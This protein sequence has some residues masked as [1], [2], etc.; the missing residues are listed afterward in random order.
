VEP[1]VEAFI[2][3][4]QNREG[5]Q[6][7]ANYGLFLTGLCDVLGIPQPD[8][9]DATT[10]NNDY[11]LERGVR[12]PGRDGSST[13]KRIDLYKRN[14][15][16]LEAKQSRLSGAKKVD[17]G[18][19]TPALPGF[20][21]SQTLGRRGVGRSWDVLMLN[22]R[23]QAEDY[24]RLLPSTHTPP[25]FV[26]VCDVGH[27]IEIY[28]NFR[29]DG[30]AFDQFPD[31]RSFR[32]YLEDLRDE[33]VRNRLRAIWLTPMALDPALHAAAVTRDIATRLAGVTKAL[34]KDGQPPEQAALFLMRVLFTMFA[35]DTGLLP[36]DCFK[37]LLKECEEQPEIF[38]SMLTDL[39]R[40]MDV[41]EFTGTIKAKVRQ[42]NGQFFK[43][44]RAL[45]LGREEIG[46]LRRA[47][48]HDWRDVEP[49]IFGTLL[50]QALETDQR[51]SLGAHYTPRRYVERLVIATIIDPLREDWAG[52]MAVAERQKS[53]GRAEEAIKT[54]RGFHQRL[55][56]LRVLDPA[57]GTGNFLYVALE[58]I[59]RLE[60]E[61]L[62]ALVGLGGQEGLIGLQGATVDPHQFL[63]LELNPRAAAIAELVLW[64]GHLQWHIRTKGEQPSE[65][66]LKA[67]KNIRQMDAVLAWEGQP[68][69]RIVDGKEVY[70]KP[71]RPDWP[72]AEFI[73]GNPPFIG[74]KHLRSRLGSTYTETLWTT[75]KDINESADFV[76]YWWDHAAEILTR[77][78]TVLRRFGFVTT[79]SI[80]QVFQRRVMERHLAK[81]KPI[82]ILYA[83]ADHPWT[84]ATEK[85]AA[86]R[87]AMTI[88]VAGKYDGRLLTVISEQG[89]DTDSPQIEVTERQGRINSDLTV[90]TDVTKVGAL[91]A[92]QG[93]SH[94][95]V[96]LHGKGFIVTRSQAEAL[97][98]SRRSGLE[99]HIRPY[100]NGRDL[101]THSRG[102]M[103]IDLFGLGAD[104]V[105][106]SFPEVYQHLVLN[107]KPE[108]DLNNRPTYKVNWWVFGEP[109]REARPAL[110]N[111]SRYIVTVQTA[112]HRIFQMIDGSILP[113]DMLVVIATDDAYFMGVLQSELHGVWVK[114]QES[115]LEDRPRYLRTRCFDPF[116]FPDATDGQ[117]AD[118]AALAEELDRHRKRVLAEDPNLT[119][120]GLY[121]VLERLRAGTEPKALTPDERLICDRGQVLIIQE[122][123][124]RLDAAVAAAYGWP[125]DLAE[126]ELLTR[127]VALNQ[128]RAKEE[129]RGRVRWL[130]PDYQIPRFG[131]EK[132]QQ[133]VAELTGEA[134][135]AA[136]TPRDS[137]PKDELG[138][139]ALVMQVLGVQAEPLSLDALAA[140]FKPTKTLRPTL[141]AVLDSLQRLGVIVQDP[142]A[143]YALY[144]A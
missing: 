103:V 69:P 50:E 105:R 23:R 54:V 72:T 55:C 13:V 81:K 91:L 143:R 40:A 95:G 140:H 37:K 96:K 4:W 34:E 100:R 92:N 133:I 36:K 124:A 18:P 29:R 47:A 8:P 24:V 44:R 58:L 32:I 35:E 98:L 68:L 19:V 80:T 135:G 56:D 28:A 142:E 123:H 139:T 111:L 107:V 41:G 43:D 14:C 12:E 26:L 20:E 134:P 1:L 5:G 7:R 21:Q 79:N 30:K 104:Q 109:R 45:P 76:M 82:S 108:R 53:E 39:W 31:R 27:C 130:R 116:P 38:P 90:G 15:F 77:R 125:G 88:A 137:L 93:I 33:A 52:V 16:I 115:T 99:N 129:K 132:E 144:R 59:K 63:G 117:R 60:G 84:K 61:V 94:D 46:E 118:I 89:I 25:P 78:G 65:P 64:I 122:L 73:I 128:A 3:R 51:R 22:A 83:I 136:D 126:A 131:S 75:H 66:I 106:Q 86:V 17:L 102:V 138:Q 101:T 62:E 11:V 112:K 87:I 114:A 70:P 85:A 10:E 74:S 113:D 67:F 141:R 49:A 127:L 110:K 48:E 120:T 6:E 9:A 119:L 57:C 42:F 121:N 2:E 71:K 97:G